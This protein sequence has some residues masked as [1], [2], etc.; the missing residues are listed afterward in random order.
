MQKYKKC[1][2]LILK[3]QNISL[4]ILKGFTLSTNLIDLISDRQSIIK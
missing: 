2:S 1:C 3:Y 4:K